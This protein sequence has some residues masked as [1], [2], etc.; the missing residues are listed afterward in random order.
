MANGAHKYLPDSDYKICRPAFFF[1]DRGIIAKLLSPGGEEIVEQVVVYIPAKLIDL[2]QDYVRM[3][4]RTANN[5][6]AGENA[7]SAESEL[8]VTGAENWFVQPKGE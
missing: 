8:K 2:D 5:F 4:L 7:S 3:L 6:Q 1:K